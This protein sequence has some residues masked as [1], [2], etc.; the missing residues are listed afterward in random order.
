MVK[1]L[2]AVLY[3]Q[4]MRLAGNKLT[5]DQCPK[6]GE[7]VELTELG[8]RKTCGHCGSAYDEKVVRK[9]RVVGVTDK[10]SDWDGLQQAYD[11][12][13]WDLF[14]SHVQYDSYS[15]LA[16]VGADWASM[17]ETTFVIVDLQPL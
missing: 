9:Y 1:R 14:A 13:T 15:F 8:E 4:G 11:D 6:V 5:T 10:G 3:A 12:R 17:S 16:D 7:E 2:N